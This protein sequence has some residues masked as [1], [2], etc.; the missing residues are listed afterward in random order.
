MYDNG[1]LR[2]LDVTPDITGLWRVQAR[3]NPSFA[4]YVSLDMKYIETWSIWL[5][6][7]IILRTI[8]MVFGGTGS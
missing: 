4:S 5:D 8:G 2:R 1:H 3:Q 6:F 7:K